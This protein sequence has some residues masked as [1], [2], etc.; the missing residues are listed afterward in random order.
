M[1][2]MWFFENP[3][4]DMS[5]DLPNPF[6]T[7]PRNDPGMLLSKNIS[8]VW[9]GHT[10]LRKLRVSEEEKKPKMSTVETALK[11]SAAITGAVRDPALHVPRHIWPCIHLALLL[12]HAR[13][14]AFYFAPRKLSR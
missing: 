12:Q 6:M 3:S 5:L 9:I 7:G 4:Q 13:I 11:A 2:V 14:W 10:K 8:R 1:E